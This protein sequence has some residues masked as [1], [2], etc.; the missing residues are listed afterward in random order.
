MRQAYCEE[1]H[2][3]C[4]NCGADCHAETD[5]NIQDTYCEV[6]DAHIDLSWVNPEIIDIPEKKRRKK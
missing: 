2:F 1:H 6:C 4:P 5:E 3:Q